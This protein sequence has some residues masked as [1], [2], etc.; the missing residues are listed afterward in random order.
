[1]TRPSPRLR[2][3]VARRSTLGLQA[4]AR[5]REIGAHR[6]EGDADGLQLLRSAG[7]D[8]RAEVARRHPPGGADEVVERASHRAD[9]QGEEGEHADEREKAC[10]ADRQQRGVR[11]ARDVIVRLARGG[12]AGA[13]ARSRQGGAHGLQI[14]VGRCSRRRN[15]GMVGKRSRVAYRGRDRRGE[16]TTLLVLGDV[17]LHLAGFVEEAARG[18]LDERRRGARAR[19]REVCLQSDRRRSADWPPRPR[20]PM[21][22][23]GGPR[24]SG[25]RCRAP[26]SRPRR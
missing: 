18:A 3:V 16:R 4:R 14:G 1:M 12:P 20:A 8:A 9:Q 5:V 15:R 22:R 23:G 19:P 11:A 13:S 2:I 21:P 17:L 7:L 6:V 10:D 25:A 24:S 26:R